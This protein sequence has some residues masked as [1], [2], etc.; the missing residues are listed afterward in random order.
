MSALPLLIHVPAPASAPTD[1]LVADMSA[2]SHIPIKTTD[3]PVNVQQMQQQIQ[4]LHQTFHDKQQRF[5]E[6]MTGRQQQL[7][8]LIAG[9]Q[10]RQLLY[11]TSIAGMTKTLSIL[12]SSCDSLVNV[13]TGSEQRFASNAADKP[14][15]ALSISKKTSRTPTLTS[16]NFDKVP[17]KEKAAKSP[18]GNTIRKRPTIEAVTSHETKAKKAKSLHTG[19]Y[20]GG[21][22]EMLYMHQGQPRQKILDSIIARITLQ[23]QVL[24]SILIIF[25]S[26]LV[27]ILVSCTFLQFKKQLKFVDLT[28]GSAVISYDVAQHFI[29]NG[30]PTTSELDRIIELSASKIF[31]I[32]ELLKPKEECANVDLGELLTCLSS[33]R[34]EQPKTFKARFPLHDAGLF[35]NFTTIHGS[36]V[37]E[38]DF[39]NF[40][41]RIEDRC[42]TNKRCA[43]SFW[44]KGQAITGCFEMN[45]GF[46]FYVV[47]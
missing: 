14:V 24:Y 44:F 12:K 2:A 15:S 34:D 11:E 47:N 5:E 22:L 19:L 32:R 25:C 18:T 30:V 1:S 41:A 31:F 26:R 9:I 10:Q 43:L 42:K 4:I 21:G 27:V 23:S 7:E 20:G 8:T 38:N 39:E 46:F 36:I 13:M 45:K 35:A 37:V 29:A 33:L 3:Q 40:Q 16:M 17:A 28:N 6:M